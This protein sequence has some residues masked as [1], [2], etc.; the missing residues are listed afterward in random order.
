[1]IT[2]YNY[3]V[4][5]FIRFALWVGSLFIPKIKTGLQER[6]KKVWLNTAPAQKPI[7]IHCASGEFEYA[8]P[9]IR[10]IKKSNPRQKVFVSY[11]SPSYRAAISASPDVDFSFPAPWDSPK[12]ISEFLSFHQPI[13]Y[14][15]A[16]TDVW[17][18]MASQ[19]FTRDI[20][21]VLFSATLSDTSKRIQNP[22]SRFIAAWTLKFISQ[23]YCVTLEDKKN[24]ERLRA[25]GRIEVLGD[26]RFDQVVFRI[27]N[28]KPLKENLKPK[29]KTKTFVCGS[30]WPE[31]EVILFEAFKKLK[32]QMQFIVAPHEPSQSHLEDIESQLR[33]FGLTFSRYSVENKFSTDVLL[34]DQVGILADLYRWGLYAFVGGSFKKTVHSVMEPLASGCITFFGPLHLNNREAILFKS[35]KSRSRMNL[36]HCV[37]SAQELADQLHLLQQNFDVS[38]LGFEVEQALKAYTGTSQTLITKIF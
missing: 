27:Q 10:E 17:P 9:V 36:A 5:P 12:I 11:F 29:D 31:D 21:T 28:P 4:F 24:F 22:L 38:T 19:C 18:G 1:M 6:K 34:V 3:L 33:K 20:P 23:I 37:H 26:T 14:L 25:P 32:N 15:I 2:L 35:L 16:R 30:T 13:A 8:K 7:I